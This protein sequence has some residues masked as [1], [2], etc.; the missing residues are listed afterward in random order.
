MKNLI[1][2][3]QHP[4]LIEPEKFTLKLEGEMVKGVEP[5]LGY[6]HR[7]I[8]KAAENCSYLQDV[9]LVERICGI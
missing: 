8:E 6:V 4:A 7:G 5:R 9:Y 3:P 1:I 2:G